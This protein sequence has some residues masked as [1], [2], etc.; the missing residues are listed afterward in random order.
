[1]LQS[2]FSPEFGHSSGGQFNQTIKSG[3]NQ[4]HGRAWEYFQNRDLNAIDYQTAL[5]QRGQGITPFNTRLD[6]NRFGG[7]IGGPVIK[8][9]LFFFTAWQYEPV[10]LTG[11]PSSACAPTAAGYNTLN[12]MFPNSNNL[13]V[14]QQYVPAANSQALPG[15]T[16]CNQTS[17]VNGT[18]IPIGD[19]G[20]TGASYFNYLTNVN[21]GD[22]NISSKDQL[23]AR[24]AFSNTSQLD[25]TAQLSSFWTAIPIKYN[26]FTLGE[27]HNFT[28]NLN[29][30]FRVGFN[31]YYA[32]LPTGA[33]TFPGLNVFP[34]I[35]IQE[36]GGVQLGPNP[37]APS[38]T[39][40]NTYQ[41][42]DNLSWVKGRHTFKFGAEYRE[43]ISPQF[44][45]Q[46]VRGDYEWGQTNGLN[47]YL[48]DV[49]PDPRDGGFTERSAGNVTYYGNQQA[50]YLYANDQWKVK[51]N[52]TVD[53]GLR[54]E[55]TT[56]P[57]S[58]TQ[59][60]PLNAISNVPGLITF[61]A[62][63]KQTTNFLPRIGFAYSPGGSGTT[64]IRGGF[65]MAVDVLYDN[66]GILSLPPQV[67]QTCDGGPPGTGFPQTGT[68]Y[69]TNA[70]FLA[71][72]GLPSNQPAP[73]T[74]PQD[75]R[76]ATSA[77][78][79]NQQLPYTETWNLGIQHLFAQKYTLD[80]RYWVREAFTCRCKNVSIVSR[81]P[82]L[83]NTCR[84]T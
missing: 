55:L 43:Y 40:V 29:N 36:L 38:G 80:V 10:G 47:G 79:P 48:N 49:I 1:M 3:T 20:F 66:L 32:P 76:S 17:T 28:P 5:A 15:D 71:N 21:S 30:E 62:P 16:L 23:R 45:T 27:Y 58:E 42:S 39:I 31:R 44:F 4:F 12:S 77:W 34:N 53:L 6:D 81:S 56:V 68:C 11:T 82:A 18:S 41:A 57:L 74:N 84:P 72:G 54:Y 61:S 35:V 73:F 46:R 70:N 63:S 8:D 33:Q 59:L 65:G 22:W 14:L 52:L 50:V 13:K 51:P 2:Q 25:N 60:Q 37:N 69:W 83:G 67:Q 24:Y 78:I 7:Q 75:A 19:V 9:K 26:L 64:S